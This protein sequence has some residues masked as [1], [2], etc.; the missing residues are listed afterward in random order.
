MRHII[1]GDVHGMSDELAEL[2]AKL[3]PRKDDEIVFVGDLI[4]KGP[5][6]AG[7]VRI[8]RELAKRCYVVLV[9]GN[10]EDTH[11]RYRKNL[12]VRP[13]VAARQAENK[14]ELAEVTAQLSPEDIEFLDGSVLFHRAG[15][16]LVVHGGIPGT[17]TDLPPPS[18]GW[19]RRTYSRASKLVLRTRRVN[20]E[21]GAFLTLD[22][23]TKDDPMWSELYDGR[24]GH[25]VYGH[26]PFMDGPEVKEHST[27]IDTGCVHGGRLT[28][29]V[30]DASGE[31]SFT[32]IK[33]GRKFAELLQEG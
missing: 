21:T 25:V 20:R 26:Q 30:I 27:G 33:C 31:R 12:E 4:D 9:E 17:L 19:S 18:W 32:S 2:L 13:E 5:D 8:V 10:H 23:S 22:K 15:D 11:R 3:Q 29:L 6:S 28:A 24:F 1:I 7:V 14:P 16:Y